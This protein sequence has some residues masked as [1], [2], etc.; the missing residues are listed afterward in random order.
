MI[1][2]QD[3]DLIADGFDGAIIGFSKGKIRKVIYSIQKCI[4]ILMLDGMDEDEASEYF[5]FNVKGAYVGEK[6]PLFK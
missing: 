4:E 6:T 1:T 3:G 2:L 5:Y